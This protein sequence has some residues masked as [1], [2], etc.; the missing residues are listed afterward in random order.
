MAPGA[1]TDKV[2]PDINYFRD[3]LVDQRDILV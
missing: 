2:A 1:H 3:K